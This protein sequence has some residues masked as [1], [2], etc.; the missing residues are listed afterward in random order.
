[1]KI[2]EIAKSTGLSVATLRYYEDLGLIEPRRE[3]NNYRDYSER[4]LDWLAF[5]ERGKQ[6]GMTLAT[7][8]TYADLRKEGDSTIN[9]RIGL[10]LAQEKL[11]QEKKTEL[12]RHIDFLQQ[13]KQIYDELLKKKK[14][15]G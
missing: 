2:S 3:K 9:E 4:D 12:E 1:L 13:K 14:S 11:L 5:I 7:L 15:G 10:L 8:K 6:A